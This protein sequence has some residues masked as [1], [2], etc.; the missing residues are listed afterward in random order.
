MVR[1]LLH[2]WRG[3]S[4]LEWFAQ[5]IAAGAIA[6]GVVCCVSSSDYRWASALTVWWIAF[7][8]AWPVWLRANVGR[9]R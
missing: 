3:L 1:A 7:A 4:P 8:V 5:S 2:Y 9:R 6:A